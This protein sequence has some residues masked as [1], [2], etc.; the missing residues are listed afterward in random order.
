MRARLC[1]GLAPLTLAAVAACGGSDLVLP[2]SAEPAELQIVKGDQQT[3]RTGAA[4]PDSL[5]VRVLDATGRPVAGQPVVFVRDAAAG[6]DVT[7]DTALTDEQGRAQARW[8]L[9][10]TAGTQLAR[11]EVSRSAAPPLT[12]FFTA[13]ATVPASGG[14]TGGTGGGT[15]SGSGG[16]STGGPTGGSTGG[17][18][19]GGQDSGGSGSGGDQGGKGHGGKSGGGN[20]NGGKGHDGENG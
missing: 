16:G 5:V 11:A 20:D 8:V 3:A 13:L 12:A 17:G 10:T 15:A 1:C 7:P 19:T 9:G 6:G 18:S 14:G 4:L 2:G